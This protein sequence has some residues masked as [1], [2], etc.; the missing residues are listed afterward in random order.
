MS[1]EI[2]STHEAS[3]KI[4][5]AQAISAL[6][7]RTSP[8]WA[9][10]FCDLMSKFESFEAVYCMWEV[11]PR[12]VKGIVRHPMLMIALHEKHI[13]ASKGYD[14]DVS[15]TNLKDSFEQWRTSQSLDSL[16]DTDEID[17]A[18]QY[19]E[20]GLTPMEAI[21]E[22]FAEIED[23][24]ELSFDEANS[25]YSSSGTLLILPIMGIA[26]MVIITVFALTAYESLA[27]KFETEK[28]VEKT[29]SK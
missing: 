21:Q 26:I 9:N 13:R 17:C 16:I 12:M 22:H 25:L 1:N 19:F 10:E 23:Y 3:T 6:S 27:K 5:V 2:S 14:A 7:E 20:R 28:A 24:E 4:T 11:S 18:V 15:E 29:I 8:E